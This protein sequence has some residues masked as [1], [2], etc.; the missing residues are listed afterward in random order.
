MRT[1]SSNVNLIDLHPKLAIIL[2]ML[3]R[4]WQI[5]V[6]Y[7]LIVTSG[8]DGAHGQFS[9]HY[10]GCAVDIRTWTTEK[11]GKQISGTTRRNLVDDLKEAL[12]DKFGPHYQVLDEA[13]HLHIA[14]KPREAVTWAKLV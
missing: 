11:S 4:W 7:E 9:R 1:K 10:V 5:N 8:C 6:G 3:D 13:D 12:D 2:P 14:F